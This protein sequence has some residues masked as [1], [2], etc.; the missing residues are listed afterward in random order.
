MMD[1]ELEE[2]TR[3]CRDI[4]EKFLF[5]IKETKC[6]EDEVYKQFINQALEYKEVDGARQ[7]LNEALGIKKENVPQ[8]F[9]SCFGLTS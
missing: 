1:M 4:R 2:L 5:I 9:R 7:E 3:V 6:M 8:V